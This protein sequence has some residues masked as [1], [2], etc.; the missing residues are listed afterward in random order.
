MN[1]V[2]IYLF[3]WIFLDFFFLSTLCNLWHTDLVYA[4]V[5]SKYFMFCG[6]IVNGVMF[7]VLVST[8][9]LL[10]YNRCYRNMNLVSLR[11]ISLQKTLKFIIKL[12]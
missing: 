3:I 5:I 7:S 12:I 4:N 8:Y 9:L 11:N 1:A 2:Y 6:I 10:L